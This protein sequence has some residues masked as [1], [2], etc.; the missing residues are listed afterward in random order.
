MQNPNGR[1]TYISS[2]LST[3]FKSCTLCLSTIMIDIYQ[4]IVAVA[5]FIE[6]CTVRVVSPCLLFILCQFTVAKEIC[7]KVTTLVF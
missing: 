1:C 5:V 2:F 3:V 4:N 7:C 6:R